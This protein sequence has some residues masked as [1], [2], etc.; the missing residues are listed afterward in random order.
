M[1]PS[2][3]FTATLQ[4]LGIMGAAESAPNAE[5]TELCRVRFNMLIGQFNTRR[6]YAWYIREQNFAFTTSQ[7]SYTIGAAANSPDFV[8]T[9]GG[10]PVKL[11]SAQLVLTD[12]TPHVQINMAIINQDQYQ[13]ITMPEMSARFPIVLYYQPTYPNGTIKPW[14]ALPTALT[15]EL[16]LQWW[17]QLTT[18]T[19]ADLATDLVYPD[20]YDVAMMF[21]LAELL[22]PVFPKRSDIE[23]I[24]RQARK[25][26]AAVQSVN[27]PPPKIQ[28]T[29]GI[30]SGPASFNFR[31][32]QF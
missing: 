24:K 15:Y 31:S 21:S 17:N 5:D 26:R 28:T 6:R 2:D 30:S 18:I 11:E 29:D 10:R 12:V 13:L 8:V 22:Y 25:A 32:R 20:G 7:V 16:N 1:T 23:D 27:V 19:T 4:T 9:A 3:L 14:P